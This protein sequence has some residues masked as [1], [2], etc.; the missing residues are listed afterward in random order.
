MKDSPIIKII[1]LFF[2]IPKSYLKNVFTCLKKGWKKYWLI[3]LLTLTTIVFLRIGIFAI[4]HVNLAK[5]IALS[6]IN[7]NFDKEDTKISIYDYVEKLTEY[8][9]HGVT[10][11]VISL[12]A[13]NLDNNEKELS[14]LVVLANENDF[15][16]NNRLRKAFYQKKYPLNHIDGS[17]IESD[18]MQLDAN[19]PPIP[20]IDQQA[21]VIP[22]F[23]KKGKPTIELINLKLKTSGIYNLLLESP[24]TLSSIQNLTIAKDRDKFLKNSRVI[25]LIT[26]IRWDDG[27]G[28]TTS[29]IKAAVNNIAKKVSETILIF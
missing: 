15:V 20:F 12:K 23:T 29:G 21:I 1:E 7:R 6:Y 17:L 2:N 13:M 22:F 18:S 5:S 11:S 28:C 3:A 16:V 25:Y 10:F 24:A 8:C 19:K 4:T 27:N 9:G 26:G 14:F